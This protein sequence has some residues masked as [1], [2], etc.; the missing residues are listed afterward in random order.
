MRRYIVGLFASLIV[1]IVSGTGASAQFNMQKGGTRTSGQGQCQQRGTSQTPGTQ[2]P[3]TPALARGVPGQGF[4]NA[5]PTGMTQTATGMT[6][7]PMGSMPMNPYAQN[8]AF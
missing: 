1:I 3:F 6:R 2:T 4:G 8:P 7:T 5:I